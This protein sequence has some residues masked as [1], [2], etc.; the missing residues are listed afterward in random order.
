MAMRRLFSTSAIIITL[1]IFTAAAD[2]PVNQ[3]VIARIKTEGFQHSQVMETLSWLSDVYG[4]RLS[5][6][7]NLRKAGEWARDQMTR[8]G[9]TNAA[10]EPYDATF[11][12]WTL[13]HFELAMTEP[14]YMRIYGYPA[15]WSPATPTPLV[16]AP[17]LVEVRS[18]E[19]FEKYRGKLRG[20]IVMNGKP[21]IADIGF[22]PEAKR[23]TDEELSKEA[24]VL[25]AWFAQ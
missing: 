2:E 10:L 24:S 23:L 12:G 25:T 11:R 21:T 20:A 6:S 22:E 18:K 19:D 13:D 8:W 15:A 16:G 3:D 4:P 5:G 9:L 1:S 7:D 14:Q 17:V